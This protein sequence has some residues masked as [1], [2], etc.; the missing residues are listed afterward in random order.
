MKKMQL[1]VQTDCIVAWDFLGSNW[2]SSYSD[3]QMLFFEVESH[4]VIC[5]SLSHKK[6][7][8]QHHLHL[9]QVKAWRELKQK[10]RHGGRIMVNCGGTSVERRDPALNDDD[11]T[12][13]WEDGSAARDASLSAMAQVFSEVIHQPPSVCILGSTRSQN[14]ENVS[15]TLHTSQ[16]SR[17]IH[18]H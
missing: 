5:G 11:G 12:W 6:V 18:Q 17:S 8:C 2:C 4:G 1:E 14:L 15:S 7:S 3:V 16:T 13:T 9:W 10:L